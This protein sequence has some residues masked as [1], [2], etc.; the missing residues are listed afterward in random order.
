MSLHLPLAQWTPAA[1]DAELMD[2]VE[3]YRIDATRHLDPEA[4][5]TLG[6]FMTPAPVA[7]FMAS[8]FQE[9]L[10]GET[11]D[12]LDAG[13]GVGSLTAA[14]I[15]RLCGLDSPPRSIKATLYEIDPLLA[16]YLQNSISVCQAICERSTTV[17]Q[18]EVVQ[19][20]FILEAT[21]ILSGDMFYSGPQRRDYSHA[22]LNPPYKKIQS[23]SE[24][25]KL[26]RSVG[27]ETTNL[28]TGFLALAILLLRPGGELVAIVPRSFC[29]GPYFK[30][31]RQL[32][33]SHMSLRQLHVFESRTEAFKEDEVLQENV[34]LYAVKTGEEA[35]VFISS[36]SDA[37]FRDVTCDERQLNQ[38]VSQHDPNFFLH[39]TTNRL[40]QHVVDRMEV[41]S[42][43]LDDLGISVSTGPV[44]DFRLSDHLISQPASGTVPL[45]YP[46][47]LR[48]SFVVWPDANSR[49][50]NAILRNEITE[51]WLFPRGAYTLVRRFSSKEER[52]R[53]V[54][55]VLSPAAI[56]T[57]AVGFENHL[58]VFHSHKEGL[59]L[60][61]AKGLAVYLNSTLVDAYFRLFNGHTQVNATDLRS[62]RY[63]SLEDLRYLGLSIK[64]Q[65]L[66]DQKSID[67][68]LERIIQRM[69]DTPS[70]DPVKAKTKIEEAL[71]ILITLGF[72]RAQQNERSALTL[73]ALLDL[74]A[75]DDWADASSP[76]MRITPI[77]EFCDEHY[78][79]KYAPN[80]R[81]TFRRQTMH[82]FVD[83]SLAVANPDLPT[84]PPNSPK[85]CYQI[86]PKALELLKTYG[87]SEWS[88]NLTEYLLEVQTLKDK[89]A[90]AREMQM[91]PVTLSGGREIILS[92]GEHS[93]LIKDIVE[94]FA[95]RFVPGGEVL[96]LGDT[97]A[98]FGHFDREVFEELGVNIDMHGKMPDVVIY[99]REKNWLILVE[100]VTSHGPV[101]GKRRE[102]LE[103]LFRGSKAGLVYVTAF[104]SRAAMREYLPD[105]S[106]ETE[107]WVA[108]APT[109]LIHFDG[110]RFLGP[111]A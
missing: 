91:V 9:P 62:L 102:E 35:P 72:P 85:S 12:I 6:Q 111:Y 38:V 32:L 55:A 65:E 31:F 94:Q 57:E 3:A 20:D 41:F 74:K 15:D 26:L 86:E 71:E 92:P 39:L 51:K 80:T 56:N 89:Y 87:T 83:A 33:L 69:A 67:Q 105:I 22:I 103:Q 44:V 98:K 68:I 76:L 47:H 54:A 49:K 27:I 99:Y 53:I 95:P 28:Y 36:S 104:P 101:D 59:P 100:A 18:T 48:G 58:N 23:T 19:K 10:Q 66:P 7:T 70:T 29:N 84:R 107:V 46:N 17:L 43:T 82:Q 30:P 96:Y 60:D 73:L 78:G 40:D 8:L 63:P 1:P 61:V 81:E 88:N 106:W 34:I 50:P 25:R 42:H 79:R 110:E 45:I 5:G 75:E 37:S 21:Q 109:H 4:K 90:R 16:E 93:E 24:H 14:L 11:V 108:S 64:G 97:G 13:A 52:R 2:L 77:M